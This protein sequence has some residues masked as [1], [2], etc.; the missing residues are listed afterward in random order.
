ML[1]TCGGAYR[2]HNPGAGDGPAPFIAFVTGFVTAYPVLQITFKR[3]VAEGDLV[4]VHSHFVHEPT[5]RG[6]AV[7]DIF[8]PEAGKIVEHRDVLQEVPATAANTNTMF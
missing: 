5:D 4:V 7:M 3:L 2:Q 1:N 8:R 6:L